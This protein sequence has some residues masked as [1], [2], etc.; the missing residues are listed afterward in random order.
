MAFRLTAVLGGGRFHRHPL[1]RRRD[2]PARDAEQG[3]DREEATS[4]VRGR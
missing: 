3:G 2:D 1:A 4:E